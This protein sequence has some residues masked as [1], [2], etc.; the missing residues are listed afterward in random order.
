MRYYTNDRL[1]YLASQ[2]T[3]T[4]LWQYLVAKNKLEDSE[5]VRI[6]ILNHEQKTVQL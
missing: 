4:G 1:N 5:F 3:A 6:N 2:V